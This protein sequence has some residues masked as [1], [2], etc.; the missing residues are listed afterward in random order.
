MHRWSDKCFPTADNTN[1]E[2][3][4]DDNREKVRKDYECE[5]CSGPQYIQINHTNLNGGW[6]DSNEP[7]TGY[8]SLLR[9]YKKPLSALI[10]K[11][12]FDAYTIAGG[13]TKPYPASCTNTF[14]DPEMDEVADLDKLP[15][16]ELLRLNKNKKLN[17]LSFINW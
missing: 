8:I 2:W 6:I 1:F 16:T 5:K 10:V 9:I 14:V 3:K 4:H 12:N 15:Y 7:Y 11:R 17:L 13:V